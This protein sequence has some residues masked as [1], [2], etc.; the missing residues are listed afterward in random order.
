MKNLLN[1]LLRSTLVGV[2]LVLFIGKGA[3]CV[4]DSNV[5]HAPITWTIVDS[6]VV[7][8]VIGLSLT[9]RKFLNIKNS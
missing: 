1:V 4:F 3:E 8:G 2:I 7:I 6:L 5:M 9:Y